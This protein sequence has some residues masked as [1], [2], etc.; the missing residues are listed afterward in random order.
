M[1][2]EE[3]GR[4]EC[5][6]MRD[7]EMGPTQNRTCQASLAAQG[8]QKMRSEEENRSPRGLLDKQ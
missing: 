1:H 8:L 4:L 7:R 5:D 6:N 3:I 2:A